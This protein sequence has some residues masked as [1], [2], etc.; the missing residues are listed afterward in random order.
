MMS[1]D[2]VEEDF[3]NLRCDDSGVCWTENSPFGELVHENYNCIISL[4]G[5]WKLYDEV[6]GDLFPSPGWCT[7]WL[8]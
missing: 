6:H 8:E 7:Q 1:K 2:I 4:S 5:G 3:S